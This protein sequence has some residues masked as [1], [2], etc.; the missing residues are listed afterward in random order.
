MVIPQ[1]MKAVDIL[2]NGPPEV[3]KIINCPVPNPSKD[4]IL[5]KVHFA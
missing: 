4:E 1:A 2:R 3:L 5:I